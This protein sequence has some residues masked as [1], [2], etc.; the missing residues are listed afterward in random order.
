MAARILIGAD[1]VPTDR[2]VQFFAD[3][4]IL[5]LLGEELVQLLQDAEHCI[6]NLEKPLA[7]VS[8]P[9][10]KFGPNLIAPTSA[11]AA[12]RAMGIDLLTLANNH[13]MDQGQEGLRS[14]LH[15][16]RQQNI[17]YIG[18]G[19]TLE[20]A[21]ETK[22]LPLGE[23]KVG[24][25]ACAEHE[26]SILT[27]DCAGANPFDPLES[28]DHV[29]ALKKKC[30]YVVVLYHGGKE[31]YQYPSPQLQKT[32]RKLIEKGAD[33][34]LCQH[35]HCI[36]C[37]E[38]YQNGTIVYGQGNFLFDGRENVLRDT[39]LLVSL[40]EDLRLS[41]IPVVKQ[42]ETVRLARDGKKTEILDSF[43]A[44]SEEIKNPD[45]LEEKYAQF[46]KQHLGNYLSF[47]AG[48]RQNKLLLAAN[49]IAGGKLIPWLVKRKFQK[50]TLLAARNFIEC[51]AH[52]ELFLY[53]L[54]HSKK[55]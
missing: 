13:I 47:L 44:R 8:T 30:D 45:A 17:S 7:D 11:A 38:V 21:A 54:T 4:D 18:V 49:R 24:I 14:T 29:S 46:A 25:Y 35:S 48:M 23:K 28:P 40:D 31:Y 50:R 2:N 33:L 3:Q 36:G 41:Y 55:E 53:G 15:A 6:F 52:R 26:F 12:Y 10:H 32:C 27:H 1:L 43:Y 5:Y 22:I 9:I 34:V 42:A 51:E 39:G 16:L 37:Q 19:D 20:A